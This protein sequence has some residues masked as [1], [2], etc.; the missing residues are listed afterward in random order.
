M[1]ISGHEQRQQLRFQGFQAHPGGA[2][3]FLRQ[4]AHA[5]VLVYAHVLR[6]FQITL[7]PLVA[8]ELLHHRFEARVFLG[9][10]PET[11][12]VADDHRVRQQGRHFFMAAS[13]TFEFLADGIFHDEDLRF[14]GAL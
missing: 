2:L 5:G 9:E 13:E 3:L 11:V 7:S 14:D 6:A 10:L 8:H 4:V 1:G 12:A